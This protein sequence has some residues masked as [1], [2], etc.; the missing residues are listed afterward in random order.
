MTDRE[1]KEATKP[2]SLSKYAPPLRFFSDMLQSLFL[3]MQRNP[4]L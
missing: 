3:L 4:K 1:K 2:P